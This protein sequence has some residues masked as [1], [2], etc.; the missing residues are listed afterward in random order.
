MGVRYVG[1]NRASA[2]WRIAHYSTNDIPRSRP[3]FTQI[4][5]SHHDY[6]F[7]KIDNGDTQRTPTAFIFG[8][9]R[10]R[11]GPQMANLGAYVI[12]PKDHGT[13]T[14]RQQTRVLRSDHKIHCP[15]QRIFL[16]PCYFH[17]THGNPFLS[18]LVVRSPSDVLV[19]SYAVFF[20]CD[21]TGRRRSWACIRGNVK[22]MA[23]LRVLPSI[24]STTKPLR[25]CAPRIEKDGSGR[26]M[27]T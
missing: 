16:H 5:L 15:H 20:P 11:V 25:Q 23:L 22:M 4:E 2:Q 9:L 12:E 14:A 10:S 6:D 1:S 13:K 21:G 19:S 7:G 3:I 27:A 26:T 17:P 24:Q 18:L 8:L